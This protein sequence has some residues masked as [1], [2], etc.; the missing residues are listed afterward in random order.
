VATGFALL[1]DLR[2]TDLRYDGRPALHK[3]VDYDEEAAGREEGNW[4]QRAM[5]EALEESSDGEGD[6]IGPETNR[7]HHGS[8]A[9]SEWL[10]SIRAT[11]RSEVSFDC[12]GTHTEEGHSSLGVSLA[13]VSG[14]RGKK[15]AREQGVRSEGE[16]PLDHAAGGASSLGYRSPVTHDQHP[17]DLPSLCAVRRGNSVA[18]APVLERAS[19]EAGDSNSLTNSPRYLQTYGPPGGVKLQ[20]KAAPRNGDAS[21]PLSP[22]LC[23]REAISP[24]LPH[25][26]PASAQVDGILMRRG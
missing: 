5:W 6:H 3:L 11:S 26:L 8:A 16:E 22:T 17:R 15:T 18:S 20:S 1:K 9:D 14:A 25:G 24:A 23:S 12:A 4:S 19:D 2:R 7:N 10:Y 13:G 21:A